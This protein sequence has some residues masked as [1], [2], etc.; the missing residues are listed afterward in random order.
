MDPKCFLAL[1]H[2]L[3]CNMTYLFRDV[4][5]RDLDLGSN[6]EIDLLRS[7]CIYVDASRRE[8]HDACQN[9]VSSFLS[10]KVIC[11]KSLSQKS[12]ILTILEL[13]SLT[14]WSNVNSDDTLAKEV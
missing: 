14:R 13:S 4:T 5:S 10:S 12:S 8:E 9:S 11:E 6:S 1:T 2:R 7:I 3:V